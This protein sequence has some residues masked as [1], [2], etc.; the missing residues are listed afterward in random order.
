MSIIPFPIPRSAA[1][2]TEPTTSERIVKTLDDLKR[3][4]AQRRPS[5]VA[6]L[7]AAHPEEFPPEIVELPS[8]PLTKAEIKRRG[9]AALQ[10]LTGFIGGSQL[11]VLPGFIRGEDG[12]GY[13]E[14][15]ERLAGIVESMPV[16]YGQDGKGDDAIVYLHYFHGPY[17]GYITEKDAE[18]A[19]DPAEAQWQA[20]GY[21]HWAQNGPHLSMGYICLPEIFGSNAELDFHFTPCTV[22]EIKRKHGM[23]VDEAPAAEECLNSDSTKP[24]TPLE[25][26][27][28]HVTGAIERGEGE[29]IVEIPPPTQLPLAII[30]T[31]AAEV[32]RAVREGTPIAT[33]ENPLSEKQAEFLAMKDGFQVGAILAYSWGYEQTNVDFH[34]II[35]RTPSSV[36]LERLNSATRETG[37]MCGHTVPLDE[38]CPHEKD[39]ITRRITQ[40]YNGETSVKIRHPHHATLWN[41]RPM[42]CSW[43]G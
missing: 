17:D 20:H 35:K 2:A 3:I 16:T 5:A 9:M 10:R 34:R 27:R 32:D 14:I 26:L 39:P 43:Y 4:F 22:R 24:A 12:Q 13:M 15:L 6:D 37:F 42:S 28:H 7:A 18:E 8:E 33:L 19:E 1:A 41:G 30:P 25:V 21:V 11:K 31:S 36:I 38:P 40:R 23:I 29:A